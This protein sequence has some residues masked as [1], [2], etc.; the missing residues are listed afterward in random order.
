MK[1]LFFGKEKYDDITNG[2]KYMKYKGVY[3]IILMKIKDD[4]KDIT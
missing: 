4:D 1:S 3:G 2:N